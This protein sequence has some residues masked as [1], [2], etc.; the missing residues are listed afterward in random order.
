MIST[1][2]ACSMNSFI[3][4]SMVQ[5]LGAEFVEVDFQEDGAGQGGYAKEM[6]KEFI[7]DNNRAGFHCSNHFFSNEL[8]CR[9]AWDQGR[10]DN[11]I[12]QVQSLGAEFVEVDF[13]EDGAGQGGYAKEMSKEFIAPSSWKSTSTNSA[14]K[15][16]TCSRTAGRVSKPRTIAPMLQSLR[17]LL[18]WSGYCSWKDSPQ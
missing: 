6:S 18:D 15:D 2:L 9:P 10:G 5:S 7:E 11:D 1:S 13:Q 3:S 16:W 4:A 8:R 14:P 12:E 17:S